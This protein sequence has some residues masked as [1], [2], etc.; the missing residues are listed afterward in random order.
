MDNQIKYAPPLKIKGWH[1]KACEV[2]LG[3]VLHMHPLSVKQPAAKSISG[4]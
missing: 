1:H 4:I 3:G 2:L